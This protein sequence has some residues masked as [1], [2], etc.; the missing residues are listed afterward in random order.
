MTCEVLKQLKSLLIKYFKKDAVGMPW[1]AAADEFA[2]CCA[3]RVKNGV[4]EVL[5][6]GYKVEF[7]SVDYVQRWSPDCFWVIGESFDAASVGEVNLGFLGL[8]D[9]A[10][11]KP[12][13]KGCYAC[14]DAFALAPTGPHYTN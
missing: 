1:C 5:I 4:V 12:L 10:G 8:K 11:W 13:C 2:I 7:V 9:D 14:Y 3:K 6:V